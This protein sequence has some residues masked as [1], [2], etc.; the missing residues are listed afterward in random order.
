[1]ARA[2]LEI[3][4]PWTDPVV[5]EVRAAREALFAES[6]HDLVKLVERLRQ[7]QMK[8][9]HKTVIRPPRPARESG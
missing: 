3:D 4:R 6:G 7:N 5:A 8:A 9:G 2:N 1:M